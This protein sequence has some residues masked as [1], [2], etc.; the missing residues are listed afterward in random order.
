ML[1]D[2]TALNRLLLRSTGTSHYQL[3]RCLQADIKVTY[4]CNT[5]KDVYK[6]Q[7][8]SFFNDLLNLSRFGLLVEI[9]FNN[10][11]SNDQQTF[12]LGSHN[13]IM[14]SI[15]LYLINYSNKYIFISIALECI[16]HPPFCSLVATLF[17]NILA[18][19]RSSIFLCDHTI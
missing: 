9:K 13:I 8:L 12:L 2:T 18:Q 3:Q 16:V 5:V 6:S 10:F 19:H 11:W 14:V 1:W 15:I 4:F 17:N 7:Y